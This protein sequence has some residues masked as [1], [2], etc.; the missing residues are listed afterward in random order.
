MCVAR[1]TCGSST[2]YLQGLPEQNL[3]AFSAKKSVFVKEYQRAVFCNDIL[4]TLSKRVSNTL[5]ADDLAIWNVSE[6]TTTATYRFQEAGHD[7]NTSKT[8]STLFSLSTS[9]EQIKLRLKDEIVPQT[10]TP[11]FLGV[12]LDTQLTW[13]PQIEKMD[14]SSLQKLALMRKLAGT[15]WG[16]NSSILTK[17][18]TATK[19]PTMEYASTMCGTAA[20]TGQSPEHGSASHTWSHENH[21]SAWLGK[22][23]NVEPLERRRSLKILIQGEKLRRL[24]SHPLHTNLAQP[25]KNRLKHQSLNHQ[26]KELSRTHQDIVDVPIE[27]LTER[28][29]YKCFWVSQASPQ[30][31]SSLESSETSRLPWSLTDS[32]TLPGLMSTLMGLL[33]RGW[34]MVAVESTSDTQ[35]VTPLPSRFLVAFS[36]PTIELRYWLFVQMQSTCWRV[37]KKMGNIAIFTDSLSTLQALN[38][39]DPDQMIQGLH[40]SLAKLTA[41]FTVSLQWVPAYVGLTGNEKADRLAKISSQA[42]QTQ[43]PV[44]YREAKTLFHSWYNGDWKKC[45]G[46]YQAHHD[47]IWRLER[48]QQTT[49]FRLRTGHYSLSAHLK[50]IGIS[51][52]SLCE[53]GQADQTPDHVLQS[54]PKYAE[55]RQLTWLQGA[56]LV[57]KLWGSAEDLYQTAGFVA[58]TRLKI[59]HARLSIAEEEEEENKLNQSNMQRFWVTYPSYFQHWILWNLPYSGCEQDTVA[60]ECTWSELASRTLHSVI[61]KNQNKR[62]TT[63]SWTVQSGSNRDTSYCRR[64]RQP[65]TSCGERRKL[66][67]SV[68]RPANRYGYLKA[69]GSRGR[70]GPHHP[71]PGNMWT[72]GLGMADWP[73]KKNNTWLLVIVLHEMWKVCV[74]ALWNMHRK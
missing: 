44:T 45:N 2:S 34:K 66:V 29:T 30:R 48:A 26:Y 25:T 37:G 42:P 65:P 28:Q 22:T 18:Y 69:M 23:A 40:S 63:S 6:H 56:D 50:R 21:P 24:P 31:N 15:S 74:K 9:K 13:K 43:N 8:N 16:A 60:C 47:L 1:C 67:I 7:I 14:R 4:T 11:T 71:I 73:Q 57:T 58:S 54:C 55:R 38:S 39:A 17:V 19:W 5:H 68:Y 32:L 35:M 41:Q 20:K 64:M 51:D 36:A 52:T 3:M 49:I 70:P 53:C 59:W 27:L 46:G 12:K 62:T 61:A 10:D 33:R 72:E